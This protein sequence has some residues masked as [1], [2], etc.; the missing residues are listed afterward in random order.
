MNV[1]FTQRALPHV[2]ALSLLSE[3]IIKLVRF[4]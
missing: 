2:S 1:K 3:P 4:E